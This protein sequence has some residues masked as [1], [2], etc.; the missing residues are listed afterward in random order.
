M[1]F[2]ATT[3]SD[4]EGMLA[5]VADEPKVLDPW[6]TR[7]RSCRCARTASLSL[8]RALMAAGLVDRIRA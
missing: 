6:V 4:F 7:M 8:N 1:V 2:G 5:A 3:F